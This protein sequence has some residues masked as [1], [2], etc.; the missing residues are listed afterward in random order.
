MFCSYG[1]V[2]DIF[3]LGINPSGMKDKDSCAPKADSQI[4]ADA[5]NP[6]F[7]DG[8]KQKVLVDNA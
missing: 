1:T 4:C 8:I 3:Y 2:T 6:S 7:I 5:I